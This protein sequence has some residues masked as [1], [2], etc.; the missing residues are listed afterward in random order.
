MPIQGRKAGSHP[1]TACRKT[2]CISSS[3]LHSCTLRQV[4][5]TFFVSGVLLAE[6]GVLGDSDLQ[7]TGRQ[8]QSALPE[9]S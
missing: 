3:V 1:W 5:T 6:A 7:K 2:S 8:M 4:S 9:P